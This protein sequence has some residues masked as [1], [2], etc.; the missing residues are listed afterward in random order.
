MGLNNYAS[1]NDSFFKD[2]FFHSNSPLGI[3]NDSGKLIICNPSFAQFYGYEIKE[4]EQKHW[5]FFVP[6]EEHGPVEK[7]W[8]RTSSTTGATKHDYKRA[9]SQIVGL[10]KSHASC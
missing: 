8:N 7:N 4:I 2:I 1:L 3:F 5:S 10:H 9:R 6:E